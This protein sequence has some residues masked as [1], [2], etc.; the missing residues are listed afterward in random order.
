MVREALTAGEARKSRRDLARA[1]PASPS[2]SVTF[3][4]VLCRGNLILFASTASVKLTRDNETAY[5]QARPSAPCSRAP[6]WKQL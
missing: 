4:P 6:V 5:P 2:S 3:S 1:P